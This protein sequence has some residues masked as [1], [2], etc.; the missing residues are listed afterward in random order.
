MNRS[1]GWCGD[2]DSRMTFGKA[3]E[4]PCIL[5]CVWGGYIVAGLVQMLI[6]AILRPFLT[7]EGVFVIFHVKQESKSLRE[8]VPCYVS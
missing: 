5:P 8:S 2:T 7:I 3:M 6:L 1:A 4:L